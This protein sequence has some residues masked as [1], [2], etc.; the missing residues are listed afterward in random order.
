MRTDQIG[1]T[2][3]AKCLRNQDLRRHA[4]WDATWDATPLIEVSILRKSVV[5]TCPFRDDDDIVTISNYTKFN[6]MFLFAEGPNFLLRKNQFAANYSKNEI[7]KHC[8]VTDGANCCLVLTTWP[9]WTADAYIEQP[10]HTL[11]MNFT[12]SHLMSIESSAS[13]LCLVI[14]TC[15][16]TYPSVNH[17]R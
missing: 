12:I 11:L 13:P 8:V 9:M 14:I 4:T 5:D 3:T 16:P 1:L 17:R 7:N 15:R 2:S 6:T 10:R